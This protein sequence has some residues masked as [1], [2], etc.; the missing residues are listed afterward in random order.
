MDTLEKF[1]LSL[2]QR[3]IYYDQ[4]RYKDSALYNVGG[5][6]E[7]GDL[8]VAR[9]F[10]AHKQ[11][12]NAYDAFGLRVECGLQPMQYLVK[13]RQDALEIKDFSQEANP[14]A[15][16][17]TWVE[18]IFQTPFDIE[19]KQLCQ[20]WL[21]KLDENTHWYV[22]MAHHLAM[23]GVGFL[24]W[25][26]TLADLYDEQA[27]FST[28]NLAFKEIQ[29]GDQLYVNGKR[30]QRERRYWREECE[31]YE[32][33][34]FKP[35]YRKASGENLAS[36]EHVIPLKRDFFKSIESF[37]RENAVGVSDYVLAV[38]GVYLSVAYEQNQ[39]AIGVQAHNRRNR[40][41]KRSLAVFTG[42]TPLILDIGEEAS[43]R[44]L[45]K[46]VSSKQ[47]RNLRYQRFP[48]S[49]ILKEL[50][51]QDQ[52]KKFS[53]VIFN[54]LKLDYAGLT[55]GGHDTKVSNVSH[56]FE[57]AP[58]TLMLWDG[59][60][61]D[62][63]LQI[64]YNHAYFTAK[65]INFLSDRLLLLL[66]QCMR[67][68]DSKVSDFSVLPYQE[69]SHLRSLAIPPGV[70]TDNNF[71]TKI[72]EHAFNRSDKL[73]IVAGTSQ[74]NYGEL[75]ARIESFSLYLTQS[76]GLSSNARV[77]LWLDR[78]P[79]M[80]VVALALL[81]V[82]AAYIP[83]DSNTP[84]TR[85]EFILKDAGATHLYTEQAF[86]NDLNPGDVSFESA[87]ED[88]V[89]SEKSLLRF[90]LHQQVFPECH[91][92][93][94]DNKEAYIIYTSGTTGKPKGVVVEFPALNAHII[95]AA[96]YLALDVRDNIFQVS[97]FAFDTFIEQTFGGLCA[98]ATLYMHCSEPFSC[99]QFFDF[100]ETN[101][102]SVTDLPLQ[103]FSAL[104]NESLPQHWL[105]SPL[106]SL[107][108]GGEALP[109]AL[110]KLWF[111]RGADQSCELIN[112]YGPTETVIT[113]VA[114][115]ITSKDIE[116]VRIGR[117][118][119]A[120]EV[121]VLD[122]QGRLKPFGLEGELYVGG[123]LAKGYI[124]APEQTTA[125]FLQLPDISKSTLY[126]TGDIVRY[127]D[128]GNL[129]F[130]GR[131]DTQ[132]KIRGFR[133]DLTEIENCLHTV[134][135]V[136]QAI[137]EVQTLALDK[138]HLIA[139][140]ELSD[141]TRFDTARSACREIVSKVLPTYMHPSAY[142]LVEAW[143]L[144][145]NAKIDRASLVYTGPDIQ[146]FVG[147]SNEI[148]A[149]VVELWSKTLAIPSSKISVTTGFFELGGDSV[150][151]I[152]LIS[153]L[154][155][156][157]GVPIEFKDVFDNPTVAVISRLIA[158]RVLNKTVK[159]RISAMDESLIEELEF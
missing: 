154:S 119:P 39:I 84:P 10:E 45:L 71:L 106:R 2:T 50:G 149:A 7:C 48:Y 102:I 27:A 58:L 82:G 24:N 69:A 80:I 28:S 9:L 110:V 100:V 90:N 86:I 83:L 68:P 11:L 114:R 23:D 113:S 73:A 148:E 13:D 89:S 42:L 147:P 32:G 51:K 37:A 103:Y 40:E 93:N 66:N 65:E 116:S 158:D 70:V 25:A 53:Q 60:K 88:C 123:T 128:D 57:Q 105:S 98:G 137:V 79:E 133:I 115:R 38:I 56:G 95:A 152:S 91:S 18:S 59:D 131:D 145:A 92:Q 44:E 21:V 151:A 156:R 67:L 94:S 122:S 108:V 144:M 63:E 43:F 26:Y 81:K 12:V 33:L 3:E 155:S 139:F 47:K 121:Y 129:R 99:K 77:A 104:L 146:D 75:Y 135:E 118:L 61:D 134:P 55:I 111:E 141:S 136:K 132:V 30:Y 143:P 124:N 4:I 138:K 15:E 101:N 159:E 22:G 72:R 127:L 6:L 36:S 49:H 78:G 112:A 8:D 16:A 142:A 150:S 62:L 74:I 120:R 140:L 97:A 14:L 96:D 1:P 87:P 54:Y 64:H 20:A 117:P 157:F 19:D 29:K 109:E 34:V 85:I 153:E 31:N 125:A 107:V 5:Y 126:R 76:G 17:K 41:Q 35:Y 52:D 46:F 130:C